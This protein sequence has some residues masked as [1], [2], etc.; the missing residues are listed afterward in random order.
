MS[1]FLRAAMG[2]F[3]REVKASAPF[4]PMRYPR[5]GSNP[6]GVD[7]VS[8]F[9]RNNAPREFSLLRA[10]VSSVLCRIGCLGRAMA[11]DVFLVRFC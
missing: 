4:K 5:A 10:Y 6:A 9:V 7:M 11:L 3:G 8:S 1:L 2:H